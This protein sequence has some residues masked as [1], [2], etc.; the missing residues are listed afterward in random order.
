MLL[1]GATG[2]TKLGSPESGQLHGW[3]GAVRASL[4]STPGEF[5]AEVQG[6]AEW[7][8]DWVEKTVRRGPR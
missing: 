7:A 4:T 5:R 8:G 6:N 3:R 2:V 1:K